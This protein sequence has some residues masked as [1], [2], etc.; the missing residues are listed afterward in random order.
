MRDFEE[1]IR[2]ND[3]HHARAESPALEGAAARAIEDAFRTLVE[4]RYFYQKVTVDLS[5]VDAAVKK[6]VDE[7]Q[8]KATTPGAGVGRAIGRREIPIPATPDRLDAL[9]GEIEKRPW[10]LCTR[11]MGDTAQAAEISSRV[12]GGQGP[13]APIEEMLI[14]FYLPAVQLACP[15]RCKTRTTFIALVSSRDSTFG[16]PFPRHGTSGREQIFVPMYR[17][18]VCRHAIHTVLVW[19]TGLRLHLCGFSPRRE[20]SLGTSLPA[21]LLAILNDAEQAVAEGDTFAAFY[22]LRTML[23]HYMKGRLGMPLG[24]A[25]RGDELVAKHNETLAKEMA[26]VLPSLGVAYEKL[27]K[28][29]HSRTGE[30]DDYRAQKGAIC[31]H[32]E[33]LSA[34]SEP[35]AL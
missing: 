7:A 8:V 9:H 30:P 23:E 4:S 19:R 1:Q 2:L 3:V 24:D 15:S 28:W 14:K 13:G 12:L 27:S 33:V 10:R 20:L 25:I 35:P 21:P 29:L 16:S 18:E 32:I 22:H 17:C 6:S 34:L 31:K 11:H 26:S 5:G